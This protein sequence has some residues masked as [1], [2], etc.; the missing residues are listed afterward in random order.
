[1]N[2]EHAADRSN[3]QARVA[4]IFACTRHAVLGK[5]MSG[6]TVPTMIRLMSAGVSPARSI[7]AR[8]ASVAR[9]EV[10][11]PASTMCRSRMPVR[12]MI[13]SFDVSTIFSRSAL[14]SRRGGT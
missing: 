7:A 1:M 14:V 2:A 13:Q 12:C 10:A 4:P 6:V 11:T 5:S 3:P 9:S 8:A